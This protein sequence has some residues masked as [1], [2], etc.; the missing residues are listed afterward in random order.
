MGAP[1]LFSAFVN[2]GVLVRV[3]VVG[4]GARRGGPE[5]RE[6][7]VFGV[8]GDDRER[9]F[10]EDRSGRGRRGNDGDGCFN[11]RRWEILDGDVRKGDTV[12]DFL[13]LKVDVRVLGFVGGGV[14]KLRA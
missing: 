2:D 14:L 5:V 13:E 9:E 7:L 10:L 4:E 11:D 3:D 1:D 6:K 12:D 8:A